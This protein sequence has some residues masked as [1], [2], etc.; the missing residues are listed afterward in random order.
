MTPLDT[1]TP[2]SGRPQVDS[3]QFRDV[4]SRFA[5]G[6][7]IVTS[8]D[9]SGPLGMAVNSFASLSLEPPLVMFGAGNASETWPAIAETGHF[10]ISVLSAD[11][12]LLSRQFSRKGA[13]RFEG[14][15][16]RMSPAGAPILEDAV[17]WMDCR[18]HATYPGGDHTL[19]IGAVD[20]LSSSDRQPQVFYRGR[21]WQLHEL[22]DPDA[23]VPS[24]DLQW[25]GF[26]IASLREECGLDLEEL[27]ER[28][29][30][31]PQSLSEIEA[32]DGEITIAGLRPIASALDTTVAALLERADNDVA[33]LV[34][35]DEGTVVPFEQGSHRSMIRTLTAGGTPTK[36][37][38][39]VG[40][41]PEFTAAFTHRGE[42]TLYVVHGE[43]EVE[44]GPETHHL[45]EHDALSYQG[46]M[47]H[48]W[49][50]VGEIAVRVLVTVAETA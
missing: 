28:C 20:D 25:V 2:E 35:S 6:V 15:G 38:E 44:L 10:A 8:C 50:A 46:E 40:G 45:G 34:R 7:T 14:V 37:I 32:G 43:I 36:L 29:D 3:R 18:L 17:A 42:E 49:R 31:E 4:L 23:M 11:Q 41:P 16:W 26:G 48:R 19:V 39:Y 22:D 1:T 5:T 9:P 27:A 13:D 24:Q 47:P 33:R 21:L 12:H 30:V